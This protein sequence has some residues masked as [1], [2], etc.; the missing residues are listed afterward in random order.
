MKR[1]N[2]IQNIAACMP[3]ALLNPLCVVAQS[4]K[5]P[6]HKNLHVSF[7]GVR[8]QTKYLREVFAKHKYWRSRYGD[9]WSPAENISVSALMLETGLYTCIKD[10]SYPAYVLEG[11][12]I[13]TH[14][15]G[16]VQITGISGLKFT[17]R[18][19]TYDE[20]VYKEAII[21]GSLYPEVAVETAHRQ[22]VPVSDISAWIEKMNRHGHPLVTRG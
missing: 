22:K 5:V 13:C 11:A 18:P 10:S 4:K 2:F 12:D 20:I 15:D 17:F 14:M 9:C 1:R 7:P 19:A 21:A 3:F 16:S 6:S 8:S